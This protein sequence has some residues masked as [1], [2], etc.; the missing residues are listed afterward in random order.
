VTQPVSPSNS[1]FTVEPGF[2]LVALGAL[3]VTI[4]TFL[5]WQESPSFRAIEQNTLIQQGGWM[6]I[7]L[8]LAA[9]FSAFGVGS[10]KTDKWWG[11]LI[12]IGVC[13]LI[14]LIDS[15]SSDT[16]YPVK[17][18]GEVD[19]SQ[20]GYKASHGIAMYVAWLGVVLMGIG[21]RVD[22][23][24][25]RSRQGAE[26]SK[27]GNTPNPTGEVTNVRCFNCQ[28]AQQ[29]P[30]SVSVYECEECGQKLQRKPAS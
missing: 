19:T 17:P 7:A 6:L 2:A 14:L 4:S 1:G 30:V 28:H 3:A 12:F 24:N 18:D 21:V 20:P 8:S 10:G 11:P 16:L 13:A 23:S 15:N 26:M 22:W 29:V 9:A 27:A 5:P 25:V